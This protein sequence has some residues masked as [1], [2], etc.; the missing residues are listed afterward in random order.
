MNTS[1]FTSICPLNFP[2]CILTLQNTAW[3]FYLYIFCHIIIINT[4]WLV[5]IAWLSP[6]ASKPH[7]A[8]YCHKYTLTYSLKT[9]FPHMLT[10][11]HTTS[12]QALPLLMAGS[13]NLSATSCQSPLSLFAVALSVVSRAVVVGKAG[14]PHYPL[15]VIS[16][17]GTTYLGWRLVTCT[18]HYYC[19]WWVW[20][21]A[22][23]EFSVL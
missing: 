18:Y 10:L 4:S 14:S 20:A 17:P 7:Y 3:F 1:W 6:H 21:R 11:P 2:L 8:F 23:V 12:P 15:Q 19:L 5:F 9:S 13:I 16:T 22:G